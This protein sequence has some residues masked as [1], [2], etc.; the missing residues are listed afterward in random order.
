M[1]LVIDL[2]NTNTVFALYDAGLC[3]YV[4]RC[5]SDAG[6]T[7]DEYRSWLYQL[8]TEA[9]L[10]FDA[11]D[12]V[13]AAS[14]VP[15]ANLNIRGLC[16]EAFGLEGVIAGLDPLDYGI[17]IAIDKPEEAGADRLIN[18]LAVSRDYRLPAIVIDFGTATTFDVVADGGVYCGGAITPGV[19][20]AVRALQN[21]AAQLPTIQIAPTENAIGTSTREAM[22]SGIY[23]GYAGLIE[24]MIARMEDELGNRAFVVAT[25][26]LASLYAKAV[27]RIDCVDTGLTLNGLYYLAEM[28][29]S[30]L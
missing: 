26:G 20:L 10:T 6:R 23:W 2:G 16:R 12:K 5:S 1:L 14:V 22:Q 4:W 30:K 24:G 19:R 25:G 21:A 3:R 7:A 8:F 27:P 29:K 18:A 28:N 13:I 17:D 15:D 9:G 11:V